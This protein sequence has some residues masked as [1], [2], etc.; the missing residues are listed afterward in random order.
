M[1]IRADRDVI[2]AHDIDEARDRVLLGRR[3]G[4]NALLP[5]EK[6]SVAIHESG[7]ALVAF[8]SEHADP[9]AKITILPAGRALGVTEQLPVDERHLYSEGY[10]LD[11]LA[12]RLGGRASENLV[13]GEA[14]TGAASDLSGRDHS[15]HQDGDR[16]GPLAPSRPHRLWL[17]RCTAERIPFGAERPYAEG[18]QEIIDQE[19]S[20]LLTEAE[21]RASVLLSDNRTALDAVIAEL[22]EKETISGEELA[23][24][25]SQ[26]QAKAES[27]ESLA[28]RLATIKTLYPSL[29]PG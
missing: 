10:L 11:S 3:D 21:E 23:E 24:V 2:S 22:L 26:V 28:A 17:R 16:M 13:I 15:R 18:T 29:K 27:R 25:V 8:L 7:H 19:V 20:R 12:V 6:R 4:S 1:A 5:E 14:S 9:V